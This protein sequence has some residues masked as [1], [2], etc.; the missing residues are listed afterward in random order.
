[1]VLLVLLVIIVVV[2][3]FGFVIIVI[4]RFSVFKFEKSSGGSLVTH[5]MHGP[6][7]NPVRLAIGAG[8]W[9]V[10]GAIELDQGQV[11]PQKLRM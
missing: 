3:I 1:M 9:V 6:D 5:G 10:C 7:Q 4:A 11:A 8:W 2:R